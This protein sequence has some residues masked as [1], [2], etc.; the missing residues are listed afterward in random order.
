MSPAHLE[1][2]SSLGRPAARCAVPGE[3]RGQAHGAGSSRSQP[4][5]LTQLF[6]EQFWTES[7]AVAA[8][9]AMSVGVFLAARHRAGH[10]ERIVAD[11]IRRPSSLEPQS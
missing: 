7:V 4:E 1:V 6:P 2:L 5:R 11:R 10:C 8:S 9:T 3:L